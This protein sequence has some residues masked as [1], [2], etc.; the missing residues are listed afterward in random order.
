M[1][2]HIL[3]LGYRLRAAWHNM[4]IALYRRAG[5]RKLIYGMPHRS[6]PD[7]QALIKLSRKMD[8][9]ICQ[10]LRCQQMLCQLGAPTGETPSISPPV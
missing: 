4:Q 6:S 9:H 8:R 7:G 5:A 1:K 2:K 3:A 10:V